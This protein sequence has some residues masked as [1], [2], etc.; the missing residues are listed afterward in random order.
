MIVI[1]SKDGEFMMLSNTVCFTGH[2]NQKLPWG[3]NTNDFRYKLTMI[4]TKNI[5]ENCI[6]N[7]KEH[8]ISGMAIGFDMMCAEIVLNLKKK[9]PHI[10]LECALPCKNQE[11]KWTKNI[12]KKYHKILKNADKIRCVF[13]YYTKDCMQ[14]RNK[15]MVN[16]SSMVIALFDGQSGGTKKTIEYAKRQDKEIIV[17]SPRTNKIITKADIDIMVNDYFKAQPH[18]SKLYRNSY[19]MF[20]N[21]IYKLNFSEN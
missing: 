8:F 17:I 21:F 6:L 10:T 3:F 19:R 7:G 16:S 4:E 18:A 11:I 20:L 2:R 5:I 9:Y 14:E 13:D 15:Y 12:Q 1:Q